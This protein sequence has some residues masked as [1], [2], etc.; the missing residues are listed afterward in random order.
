MNDLAEL[1]QWLVKRVQV[2]HD[3]NVSV[4]FS[5][6]MMLQSEAL[7]TFLFRAAQEMLVNAVQHGQVREA[8]IRAA[9]IGRYVCVSVADRGR[10][11]DPQALRETSG[12]G[13]LSIR[14]RVE[15]LGGRMVIKSANAKGSRLSIVVPDAP[16]GSNGEDTAEE[17][18]GLPGT[19]G[20]P[21]GPDVL[22]VL[23]VDDHDLVRR[24]LAALLQEAPGI[25]LVGQAADG[26]EAV[27]LAMD[28]QPDVVIMD[29]SMPVMSGEQAT[30]QIKAV[31]P[32][33]RVVALSMYDEADKREKM[34]LAGAEGYILKTVGADDL[35]AAL[36]RQPTNS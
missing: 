21:S 28:L 3:L 23:L 14:E 11:F 20:L 32:G 16:G 1:L 22:R 34:L 36:R 27:N 6:D 12:I 2:Q 13:L 8:T 26:R 33:T 10:G 30:R 17:V 35:I 29:A 19:V 24:G 5:G 18:A 9:R 31:L 4:D 15:L 25:E 7:A